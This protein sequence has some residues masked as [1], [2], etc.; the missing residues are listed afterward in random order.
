MIGALDGNRNMRLTVA[1]LITLLVGTPLHAI[2]TSTWR[3]FTDTLAFGDIDGIGISAFSTNSS[4]FIG[5]ME[6]RF[7]DNPGGG[8]NAPMPLDP[9]VNSLV[10]ADVNGGDI[11]DF[12]FAVPMDEGLLYI[13]NFDSGSIA[14]ITASGAQFLE[15]AAASPSV[16]FS[17][18]GMDSGR[19]ISANESYNGEGDAVLAFAGSVTNVR[20]NYENGEG[21][22]GVFYAFAMESV[23]S[24]P[25]ASTAM[26]A[27]I[28]LVFM[29]TRRRHRR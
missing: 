14:T 25:E 9:T 5:L 2:T 12:L 23:Q 17:S 4:P 13:E 7:S 22:N 19:L 6:G 21:A 15:L 11:Q 27:I 29:T 8:W 28:A 3:G 20:I 24:V 26:Y 16:S 1:L 18:T 10:T